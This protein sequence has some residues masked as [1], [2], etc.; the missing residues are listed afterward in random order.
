[1]ATD[2]AF[3]LGCVALVS[4]RVPS[5]LVVF[6]MAL[7]IFDDLGAILVIAIF[8]GGTLDVGA[9]LVAGVLT[10]VLVAMLWSGVTRVWPYAVAGIALWLAVLQSGIHATI[11]GVILGLCIPARG[12]RRP[13]E[14]LGDLERAIMRLRRNDERDLDAAGPIG[15]I[16]R[17][18][19]AM[20]PPLDRLVHGLH[21]WVAFLIVPVFAIANAGVTFTTEI[22]ASAR[23]PAALGVAFGLALGK[24]I[25]IAGATWIAVRSG[26]APK[27]TGATWVQIFAIS[28]LAGIGFTMS[29]FVATLAFPQQPELQDLSK[30][31]IFGASFFCAI[32]GLG[33]LRR[34]GRDREAPDAAP[35]LELDL[36]IPRFAEG[37]RLEAW[38]VGGPVVGQSMREVD[39]RSRF[40]V[41]A[42]GV[43]RGGRGSVTEGALEP[44]GPQYVFT[45]GDT[46][47]LVGRV[48]D[49][50]RAIRELSK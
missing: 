3:A 16:E 11:A 8:Y 21:G 31:G 29:I 18:L 39:L 12:R 43:A 10:V 28:I 26:L 15:A 5:A 44:V 32:V 9:L 37:F 35:D 14:V 40:D 2:I 24:P 4:R 36:G 19:E 30:L 7:A 48:E 27:P 45:A 23:S 20:Q 46:L 1:M 41:S 17:H 22:G 33:I 34:A 13:S 50:E 6:L 49:V 47:L 38:A 42:V 25:G